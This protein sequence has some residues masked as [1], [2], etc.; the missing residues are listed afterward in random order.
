MLYVIVQG[1]KDAGYEEVQD[2]P[3]G[4]EMDQLQTSGIC[5]LLKL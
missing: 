3:E 5:F 4:I 2:T 1:G